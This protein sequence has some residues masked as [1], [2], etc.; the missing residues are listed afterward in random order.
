MAMSMPMLMDYNW[1]ESPAEIPEDDPM[2]SPMTPPT[3]GRTLA[4][5][6]MLAPTGV[7]MLAPACGDAVRSAEFVRE[8]SP[9]SFRRGTATAG[10][11]RSLVEDLSS[12]VTATQA[13]APPA[14][15][16]D[17]PADGG[18]LGAVLT[19]MA[20]LAVVVFLGAFLIMTRKHT[21]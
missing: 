12:A 5:A 4:A 19:T 17:A 7:P 2:V 11:G 16:V 18:M 6:A 14:P 9:G 10:A 3:F 8:F 13:Q 21:V 1:D 15:D 20:V